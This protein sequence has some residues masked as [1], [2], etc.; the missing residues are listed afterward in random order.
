LGDPEIVNERAA[1]E[2][3][4]V[5]PRAVERRERAAEQPRPVGMSDDR[6]RLLGARL[7]GLSREL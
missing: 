7:L 6:R 2:Q 4:L 3:L 1:V 5:E